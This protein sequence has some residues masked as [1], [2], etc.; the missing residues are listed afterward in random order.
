MS[1]L[2]IKTV[3]QYYGLTSSEK[4]KF[5][6]LKTKIVPLVSSGGL[7]LNTDLFCPSE[8]MNERSAWG[9]PSSVDDAFLYEWTLQTA[10]VIGCLSPVTASQNAGKWSC[11]NDRALLFLLRVS[12]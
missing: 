2:N 3:E 10:A 8:G 9:M 5:L 1:A 6:F 7:T 11:V 12:L 4:V